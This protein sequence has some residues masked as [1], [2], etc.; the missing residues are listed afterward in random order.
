MEGEIP[1]GTQIGS[2]VIDS[3]LGRGGMGI[4]YRAFHPRLERWAAIKLLPPIG[5]STESRDRFERE[6]RAV[7]RLRHRHILSVFDYGEYA[8]QPYMVVEYMPNGALD[9]RMPKAP[10]TATQALALLRPLGEALDYAHAQGVLHRDVKPANVFL[11]SELQ[12]VLADFGLAK[13]L[14]EQSLT[15][16]GM[17]SGTPTHISPEQTMGKPLDAQS[18]LYSLAV[19][20]YQ[21]LTARLPFKGEGMMDLLYAHVHTDVP[22]PTSFNPALPAPVD[23]VML[24]A[25]AKNPRE[26]YASAAELMGTLEAAAAGRVEERKPPPSVETALAVP[27]VEVP[28]VPPAPGKVPA[29]DDDDEPRPSRRRLFATAAVVVVLLIAAGAGYTYLSRGTGAPGIIPTPAATHSPTVIRAVAVSPPSPLKMGSPITVSGRGLDPHLDA[30]A[31]VL[32]GNAV[33][34]IATLQVQ[35]NGSFSVDGTVPTD[36]SPGAASVVACNRDAN[37]KSVDS[38]CIHLNVTITR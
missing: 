24:R 5:S 28:V 12:P 9:H 8:G 19:I 22:P 38:Q 36:L 33:H 18:D 34:P 7:A 32:Q 15:A 35:D 23:G 11:D 13:M 4:V 29:P 1:R 16:S 6:A 3:Y 17:I 37:G 25:L 31:G 20:G 26:R 21:L 27:A 14:G 30:A 2:Y 10:L